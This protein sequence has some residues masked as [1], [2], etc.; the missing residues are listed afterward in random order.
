[1]YRD[2]ETLQPHP[3]FEKY[4]K[5]MDR[6]IVMV[7]DPMLA[8][9]GSAAAAIDMVK[10]QGARDIRLICLVG[11]PEGSRSLRSCIPMSISIWLP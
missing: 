4:P 8:T 10:K 1:M 7:V 9:G 5:D 11:A 2:E 6:S 3:Y